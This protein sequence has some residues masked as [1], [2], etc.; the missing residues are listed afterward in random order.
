MKCICCSDGAEWSGVFCAMMCLF[1][2]I[3]FE[4]EVDVF[5]V[6]QKLKSVR[7]SFISS[8]VSRY[9]RFILLFEYYKHVHIQI[10]TQ[11]CTFAFRH[12]TR[13]CTT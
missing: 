9:M 4:K 13:F 10:Y 5:E 11:K 8:P 6:V 3:F 7:P 12:S 2:Q 1:D